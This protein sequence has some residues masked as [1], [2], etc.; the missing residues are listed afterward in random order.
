[1][2]IVVDCLVVWISISFVCCN[3]RISSSAFSIG[4]HQGW[5]AVCDRFYLDSPAP[6]AATFRLQGFNLVYAVY[7]CDYIP[8]VVRPTVLLQMDMG[9]LTS[10][11]FWVRAVQCDYTTG[12]E[13]Y[14]FTTDG[15]EIFNVRTNLGACSTHEG[16]SDTNKSAQ[17][18]T[19]GTE[20]LSLTLPRQGIEPRVFGFEFRRSNH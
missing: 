3:S 18:L 7:L 2:A 4:I 1:M 20:K 10:T 8:P 6:W 14:S 5:H 19:R 13:A 15:Y 17:E 9:S 11:R 12:C 16:G